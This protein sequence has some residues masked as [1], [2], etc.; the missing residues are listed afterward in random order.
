[1][2]VEEQALIVHF[3]Y[4]DG[5]LSRLF[6]LEAE[7]ERAIKDAAVGEY[8]GNEIATDGS[9]G[10]LY[11]YG[12]NADSLAETVFPILKAAEFMVGAVMRL[13]YGPPTDGVEE[14]EIRISD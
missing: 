1:M 3:Q 11:M 5:N 4:G 9:D 2:T 12:P 14:R 8:D 10:Y 7:L 6:E 13:R